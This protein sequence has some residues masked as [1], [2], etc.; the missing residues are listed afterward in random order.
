MWICTACGA[1]VITDDSH[2]SAVLH[3]E[4]ALNEAAWGDMS[5]DVR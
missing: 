2:H 1:D 4:I 5:K 3:S